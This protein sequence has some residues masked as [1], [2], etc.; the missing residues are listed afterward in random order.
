[1]DLDAYSSK[2]SG[3]TR[4]K[5]LL[6]V[7][8]HSSD[9][10]VAA[11]AFAMIEEQCKAT[12][13]VKRYKEV[14]GGSSSGSIPTGQSASEEA[15]ES[16]GHPQDASASQDEEMARVP[17]R[18]YDS[19]WVASQSAANRNDKH[20]LHG[21][22]STAQSHLHKDAIRSAYLALAE[23]DIKTGELQ[24]ALGSLLRATDYSTSRSQSGQISLLI[25]EVCLAME[26]YANVREYVQ[27]VEHTLG[28]SRSAAAPGSPGSSAEASQQDVLNKVKI[29]SGL[30]RLARED[31]AGAATIFG[32]LVMNTAPITDLDWPGVAS[33]EDIAL[34]ASVLAL[35]VQN[36][37]S[38]LELSEHPEAL[39]LV[40]AMKELL[41]QWS[42]ANYAQCIQAVSSSP[43]SAAS[44]PLVQLGDLY[45][46]SQ[47]WQSLSKAIQEKCLLEYLKPY[48]AVHLDNMR[49]LFPSISNLED[50]LVNLMTRNLIP[51]AKIDARANILTRIPVKPKVDLQS[52][53]RRVLDDT[54]SMLIRLA[55]LEHNLSVQ[56]GR[57]KGSRRGGGGASAASA[58]TLAAAPAYDTSESEDE[59]ML[60]ADAT[61]NTAA[62]PEDLY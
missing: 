14:F 42:R 18:P 2:Y 38:I 23:H 25:L 50:T 30:E 24:E 52:M 61:A 54:H 57:P 4:L 8:R 10:D 15:A 16:S 19:Q 34:Y 43:P 56:D 7:A 40:P 36:R 13:N 55:C 46:R 49:Q 6:L 51:N 33:A 41:E 60:D 62:N 53:E 48:Q 11:Q 22:L 47:R 3:E 32:K 20:V 5:R 29:A 28:G 12:G 17:Q 44:R 45:L 59:L 58:G 9:E 21:R 26:Q 31:Y 37:A 39:E 35:A 27:K 1:M